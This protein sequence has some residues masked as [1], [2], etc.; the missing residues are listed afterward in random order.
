M[1][2]AK[3]LNKVPV[4]L[5]LVFSFNIF[6]QTIATSS[7]S[8]QQQLPTAKNKL[9]DACSKAYSGSSNQVEDCLTCAKNPADINSRRFISCMGSFEIINE[10]RNGQTGLD[11]LIG[12]TP[13]CIKGIKSFGC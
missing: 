12:N 6:S 3:Y 7:T 10:R 5:F 9:S 2:T 1:K 11:E 13:N 4:V 8:A